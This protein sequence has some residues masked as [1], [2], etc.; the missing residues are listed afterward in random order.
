V[1][2]E[3]GGGEEGM[4]E[5]STYMNMNNGVVREVWNDYTEW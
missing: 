1:E 4:V 5:F 3:C 2:V